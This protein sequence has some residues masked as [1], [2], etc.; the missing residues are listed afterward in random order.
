M[1]KRLSDFAGA[2]EP[3]AVA[4]IRFLRKNLTEEMTDGVAKAVAGVIPAKI[5]KIPLPRFVVE[6]FVDSLLPEKLIDLLEFIFQKAGWYPSD[7]YMHP[8]NIFRSY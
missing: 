7:R 4:I 1:E 2:D 3:V 5:W 6:K 8:N